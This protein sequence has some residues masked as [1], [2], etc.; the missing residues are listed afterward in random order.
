[1]LL[2]AWLCF[3]YSK[4]LFYT[5]SDLEMIFSYKQDMI[6]IHKT[7]KVVI[8]LETHSKDFLLRYLLSGYIIIIGLQQHISRDLIQGA[9][10][11]L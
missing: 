4:C 6:M 3:Y 11:K 2:H 7:I 8:S 9:S 1:M 5:S 10:K